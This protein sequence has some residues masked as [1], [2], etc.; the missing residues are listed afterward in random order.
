MAGPIMPCAAAAGSAVAVE[1]ERLV[2][3]QVSRLAEMG[4]ATE[5]ARPFC[6]GVTDVE[7]LVEALMQYREG[8]GG[9]SSTATASKAC[10][11]L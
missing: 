10:A 5:E 3:C 11:V 8:N 9:R 6:D 4:F 1:S 7:V 2:Q